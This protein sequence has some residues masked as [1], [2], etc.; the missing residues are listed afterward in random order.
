MQVHVIHSPTY[1]ILLGHL[2]DVLM[3][4]VVQNLVNVEQTITIQP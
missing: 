3:Q 1:E 2:F 4:S